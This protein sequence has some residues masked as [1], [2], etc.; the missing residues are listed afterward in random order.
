MTETCLDTCT[1]I[2]LLTRKNLHFV[3]FRLPFTNE[4]VCLIQATGSPLC[5]KNFDELGNQK[6][7]VFAPFQIT[8]HSPLILMQPEIKVEGKKK[9]SHLWEL[10]EINRITESSTH[11]KEKEESG[12]GSTFARYAKAFSAFTAPL[13]KKDFSKLVLSRTL[14][15]NRK[16]DFSPAGAFFKACK[17]YENAFVYLFH[18][19]LTGTWLGS[20]PEVL[21]ANTNN[22]WHTMAL[23]GTR[24]EN[25]FSPEAPLHVTRLWDEKNRKEQQLVAEYIRMQL[26]TCGIS[27]EESPTH[28]VQAGKVFH[29]STDF[30]FT[31]KNN[32]QQERTPHHPEN[33]LGKLIALLHPTPAVCGLPKKE[34]FRFI[35]AHEGYKRKYYTGFAGWLDPQGKTD[36]YV[37]LRCMQIGKEWLTLYAGGGLLPSSEVTTEWK[38]TEDKLQTML[39]IVNNPI[40]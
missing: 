26:L 24:K 25:T 11:Y 37:N 10:P 27:W 30:Y 6:G 35:L 31:L 16:K 33:Q 39:E 3:L 40:K 23:A 36:L 8:E 4:P 9:L 20:T 34:A 12:E 19:P 28:T 2:D 13:K 18:S 17:Q 7:F 15:H 5:L 21:L 32:L 14:T 1:G 22:T 38:E 29:L